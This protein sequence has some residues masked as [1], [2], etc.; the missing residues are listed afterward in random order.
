MVPVSGCWFTQ[1]HD[2]K[3]QA[4]MMSTMRVYW[5][6]AGR[7]FLALYLK[8]SSRHRRCLF[9]GV[10]WRE[11]W[12]FVWHL[13]TEESWF[14]VNWRDFGSKR[15]LEKSSQRGKNKNKT[16]LC[17]YVSM[18]EGLG[19]M[20]LLLWVGLLYEQFPYV[21]GVGWESR[22]NRELVHH[23]F[24]STLNLQPQKWH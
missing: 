15:Y 5:H 19:M 10:N 11:L 12:P 7:R 8:A 1:G 4:I 2:T 6:V 13:G 14:F 22:S 20:V 18:G 16:K 23:Q 3:L 9:L 24:W 21:G 17:L